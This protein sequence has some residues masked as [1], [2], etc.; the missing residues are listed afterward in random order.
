VPTDLKTLV[1]DAV[2]YNLTS[3][4]DDFELE[5][6]GTVYKIVAPDVD[7]QH[8]LYC[9]LVAI[10]KDPATGESNDEKAR[11]F[12]ISLEEVSKP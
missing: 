7:A 4:G 12:R 6:G 3:E 10:P 1:L 9:L 2:F 5:E 8:E 11:Y